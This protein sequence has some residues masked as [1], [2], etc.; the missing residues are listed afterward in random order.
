MGAGSFLCFDSREFVLGEKFPLALVP[1]AH[2]RCPRLGWGIEAQLVR[3]RAVFVIERELDRAFFIVD[4]A[5]AKRG[6]L[7][8]Q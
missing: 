7:S 5:V 8:I 2:E 4:L 6:E 3:E 1:L